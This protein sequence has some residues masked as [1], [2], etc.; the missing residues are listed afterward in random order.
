MWQ[1][2]RNNRLAGTFLLI[3]ALCT[4]FA[5]GAG[6]VM[7]YDDRQRIIVRLGLAREE[8]LPEIVNADWSVIET[9]LLTLERADIPLGRTSWTATGGAIDAHG[10]TILYA[11]PSGHIATIDLDDGQIEYSPHRVPMNFDY[12]EKNV[13]SLHSSF[14]SDWFRVQDVLIVPGPT[15]ET[16]TLYVSHHVFDETTSVVCGVVSQTGLELRNGNLELKDGNW[17]ELY[18]MRECLSMPE[19][20]W[21][22]LGLEGGGKMLQ[23][24]AGHILLAVGDYGLAW[25]IPTTDR[26]GLQYAN[27]FSK[28]IRVNL[29]TGEAS[30]FANGFRNPQGLAIDGDGQVWEAEHGP[31]GGDEINLITEGGD[32]GWPTVSLGTHYGVPRSPIPTNPVQGRHEGF[33][34]PV[35]AFLPS[36]GLSA[37]AVIPDSPKAFDLW[38]GDLL[39][40]SLKGHTLFRLRRDGDRLTYSE[41]IGLGERLRDIALL[42]NGWIAIL[43]AQD[44]NL[45][46]LRDATGQGGATS[47]PL[48]IKGYAA[49][50][51]REASIREALGEPMVGRAVFR[52]HCS[53]CH[54]VNGTIKAGPP[55]N[56]VVNRQ[57]GAIKDY[58]YSQDLA[59][60]KR[61][62]TT[63]R[64]K[65]YM[66]DPGGMYP[67]TTMQVEYDLER[68]QRREL[69]KYLAT[70]E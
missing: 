20:N 15:N 12:L 43:G 50:D 25:E 66:N 45:I 4:A 28:I 44:Q 63:S 14:R 36:V 16:A 38:A 55:L 2:V 41:P 3:L 26:V 67:G 59:T 18:R 52:E 31:Q 46:L 64:L 68:W 49:V 13:F 65:S 34:S 11:S 56:G 7:A 62:W 1:F 30:V 17:T 27:D 51:V 9:G 69:V 70:T 58:P 40:T 10:N 19:F 37:I 35:T 5:S 32:Y 48:S 6:L 54:S 24:D 23:L 22:Y 53:F 61:R 21:I 33:I 39:A 57:T 29:S 60:A 47:S 42:E 8:P